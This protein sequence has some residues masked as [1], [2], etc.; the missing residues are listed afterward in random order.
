MASPSQILNE[1]ANGTRLSRLLVDKGTQAMRAAFDVKYRPSTLVTVLSSSKPILQPLRYKVISKSHWT[2][3]YPTSGLPDSRNFDVTLLSVLLRNICGLASPATGW[4]IMPPDSDTSVAANI[5]RIR[6]YRNTV[7]AH[8]AKTEIADNEFE[9]LWQKISKAL[10]GL[11]IPNS[12]LNKL[13]EAPLSPEEAVYIQQLEDWYKIDAKLTEISLETNSL[14]KLIQANLEKLHQEFQQ[15]SRESESVSETKKLGK[16]DFSGTIR[17]LNKMFLPGT[18]QWLFDELSTWFTDE[19]S[20]S[21]VMVLTADPGV[22][23]SVFA[24][25]VCRKYAEQGQ[26]AAFHFCKYNNSDYRNPRMIIESLASNMCDNVTGFRAKLDDQ[27]QRN[28]SKETISDAFRVLLND[29]LHALEK[30]ETL[31]LV[32]DALDESNV[33]GKSEFLELISEEFPKLPPWIKI[34][35]TSRPELPVREELQHL[36]PV[37]IFPHDKNNAED[38]L[39]YIRNFLSPICDDDTVLLSLAREC[40]GSFL[41]AYH[42][43]MELKKTTIQ[44]TKENISE[45]VPKGIC[46]FYKRQFERLKNHLDN[47]GLSEIKFKRLLEALAAAKG[48]LPLSFLPEC[49]GLPDDT[50]YEVRNAIS[51]V[52]SLILPVYDDCLTVYH[53]SLIDWLTSDGY[54]EH[55]FTVDSQRGQES[56]WRACEKV[57]NQIISLNTLSSFKSTPL[58]RYALANGIAHMIQCADEASYHW[59]VH[60][61]IVYWRITIHQLEDREMKK[62]W[63][64]IVKN[65]VSSLSSELL[66]ELNWHIR[67]FQ[68][69][70]GLYE[71]AFYLQCVANKIN[72]SDGSWKKISLARLLLK[73][74]QYFWFED[75]GATELTNS[76][77]M[78]VSLRT[79]VTCIGVSS[80]EQLLAVGYKDGWISIFRLANFQEVQIFDTMLKSKARCSTVVSEDK[81]MLLCGRC[82]ECV[83]TDK[84]K[85]LPFCGDDYGALWSCSFSPSGNRLVTCDRSEEIKLWDVNS[86]NSIARLQA[87]G[88]VDCCCFSECGLFIVATNEREEGNGINQMD[89][90]T[91]WNALTQLRVDRRYIWSRF[92]LL[93]DGN[94]K[95]Q[96]FLS[97]NGSIIDVFELPKTLLVAR[98]EKLSNPYLLPVKR[99]HWRNCILHHTN[100]SVKSIAVDQLKTIRVQQ[101]DGQKLWNGLPVSFVFGRPCSCSESTRVVPIKVQGLYVVPSFAKLNIFRVVDQSSIVSFVSESHVTSCCCFSPDGSFLVTCANGEYLYVFVWDT[102]LCTVVQVFRFQQNCRASGCWWSESLLWIYDG[103]LMKIPICNG[104]PLDPSGAQRVKFD[105]KPTNILTYSDVLIFIDQDNSVNVARIMGGELQYVE[106][107]PVGNQSICAAVSPCNLVIFTASSQSFRVWK[108]EQT[109]SPLHWVVSNTGEYTDFWPPKVGEGEEGSLV[110]EDVRCKC[111]VTSDGSTGVLALSFSEKDK[112]F[113]SRCYI[114]LVDLKSEDVKMIR[115]DAYI[116]Y[117]DVLFAGK[118]YCISSNAHNDRLV[119][120]KLTNGKVVAEWKKS[121]EL[122]LPVVAHS[123]NDLVAYISTERATITL[124]K[125]IVQE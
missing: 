78:S 52:M 104:R 118:Y 73:Q 116:V 61:T 22:G 28:H 89:A 90:F 31:L 98:L 65:S 53:K 4:D 3:L 36:N 107:L 84:R 85:D 94:M 46:S 71:S 125:I 79:D 82:D 24:A 25:E 41:Y 117:M 119:A 112:P 86:G 33:A 17:S 12:E 103:G 50:D 102:K 124:L 63:M 57:F 109:T 83:N 74:G 70:Y 110:M 105:W 66:Q 56:L 18:R 77:C 39:K 34:L 20:D 13:K 62:E 35:I 113:S 44:L 37:Q 67:L 92:R 5:V 75:L 95:T 99:Y 19:D 64:E 123:K 115:N 29:P 15:K 16:C 69:A 106:K 55:A 101:R 81:S 47:L 32:I 120:V 43:R 38:L 40:K 111:C 60:V 68:S 48:P 9:N 76:F 11:G 80:N 100:E 8:I 58:T 14:V 108:E 87:G 45:L 2:L 88:H 93:S 7:Y 23:K 51:E 114:I 122:L 59:A 96:L 30:R 91:V 97:S 6:L 49:L 1:Q 26:L 54:K 21:T 42:I 121:R 72:C 27:L 10:I